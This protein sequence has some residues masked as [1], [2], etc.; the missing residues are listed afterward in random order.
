MKK[1]FAIL[2]SAVLIASA[3]EINEKSIC[4]FIERCFDCVS[5]RGLR[6]FQPNL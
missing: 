5:F 2:L 3:F 6:Q 4:D 1:V